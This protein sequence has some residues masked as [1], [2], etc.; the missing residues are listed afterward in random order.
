M[1]YEIVGMQ[2]PAD[3]TWSNASVQAGDVLKIDLDENKTILHDFIYGG[4][5]EKATE[6]TTAK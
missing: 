4:K 1:K 6:D 2:I 3:G 5:V